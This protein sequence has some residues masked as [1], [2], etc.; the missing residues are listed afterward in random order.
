MYDQ[1]KPRAFSIT[2]AT[3]TIPTSW[4]TAVVSW[5]TELAVR[6]WGRGMKAG[7]AA[8]AA[9]RLNCPIVALTKATA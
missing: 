9:G 2:G 4:P 5:K 8:L 1:S 3:M 6:N 7:S